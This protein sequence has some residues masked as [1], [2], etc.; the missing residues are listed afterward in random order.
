METENRL[1]LPG[2]EWKGEERVTANGYR[3]SFRDNENIPNIF[4]KVA[5]ICEYTQNYGIVHFK[6]VNFKV[7]E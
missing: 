3:V 2:A 4:R 1:I 7:C 5:Q 6:R